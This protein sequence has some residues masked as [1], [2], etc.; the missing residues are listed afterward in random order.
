MTHFE[1][2]SVCSRGNLKKKRKK[3]IK[4]VNIIRKLHSIL[5]RHKQVTIYISQFFKPLHMTNSTTS[6]L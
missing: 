6:H 3:T 1:K 4:G 5:P 2:L